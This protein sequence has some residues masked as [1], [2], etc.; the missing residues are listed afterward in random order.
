MLPFGHLVDN[1][2]GECHVDGMKY[3]RQ[4]GNVDRSK[5]INEKA[6]R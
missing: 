6:A 1:F 3:P 4:L 2:E 5:E